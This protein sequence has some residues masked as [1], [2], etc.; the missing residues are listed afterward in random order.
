MKSHIYTHKLDAMCDTKNQNF[1]SGKSILH[2][3]HK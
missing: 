2:V 3:L 1:V